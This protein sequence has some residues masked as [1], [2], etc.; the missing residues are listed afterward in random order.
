MMQELGTKADITWCPGC[1]NFGILN[2]VKKAVSLLEEE[3]VSRESLFVL[4]GIGCHGKIMDYLNLSSL[5][6]IHGRGIAAAQGV[7]LAN[8]T[9]NVIA[10][11]GDGDSYGEG[12]EHTVFAAKRNADVTLLVHD[13]GT[14][15]L[16]TGQFS[17]TSTVGFKGPSAPKGSIEPPLN[18]LSLLLEAGATFVARGYAGRLDHLAHLIVAAV[19]HPGFSLIDVLQPS[20]VFNNTYEEYNKLV[21]IIDKPA[22]TLEEAVRLAKESSYLPIGVFYEV[23]RPVFHKNLYGGWNPVFQRLSREQRREPLRKM[24]TPYQKKVTAKS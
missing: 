19:K 11:G 13:N 20:V 4:G 1:G 23:E 12:L 5:Y 10:F 16:T 14:Y 15:A 6:A 3:G 17:P 24:V 22:G 21:K 18:P 2:A 7:K 8:P 9:L